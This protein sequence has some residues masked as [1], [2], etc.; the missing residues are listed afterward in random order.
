MQFAYFN[1]C[2]CVG[3]AWLD[4]FEPSALDWVVVVLALPRLATP[5]CDGPLPQAVARKLK[6][7]N[8]ARTTTGRLAALLTCV[9]V[10][11]LLT[12]GNAST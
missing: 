10:T 8:A 11:L 12:A 9:V 3:P 4:E 5:L 1:N 6:A 7:T 2:A